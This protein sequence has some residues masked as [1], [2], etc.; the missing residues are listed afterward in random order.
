MPPRRRKLPLRLRLLRL[1]YCIT[2]F[3]SPLKLRASAVR[4][5]HDHS[6]PWL[7]LLQ[8]FNPFP[9]WLY[10][11]PEPVPAKEML[12]NVSLM[13]ARR[14]HI[15]TLRNIPVWRSRDTSLRSL[16]RLYEAMAAGE[17]APIGQEVEYFWYQSRKRWELHMIE[18]PRDPDPIRYAILACLAEELVNA[19]NWRLSLGMR[20]NHRHILRE[21]EEEPYPPYEP[22]LG[23]SWTKDVPPLSREDL[24]G[25]PW[26]YVNDEGKL[27]LED[28]GKS[29]VFAGRNI[30]TNVGWLYT[31]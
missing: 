23:P 21:T 6:H 27:V 28:D 31:I 14:N 20:R 12:G 24:L 7:Y 15:V 29:E 3:R 18:N 8:L 13:M 16:Y 30:V 5:G 9:S 11:V 10:P 1:Y 22:V 25:L 26:G 2:H 17:Y 19:F 4:L